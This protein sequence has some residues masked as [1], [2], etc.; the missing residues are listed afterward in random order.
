[1]ELAFRAMDLALKRS[2]AVVAM[3]GALKRSCAEP[4]VA[5]VSITLQNRSVTPAVEPAKSKA[6]RQLVMLG[7]GLAISEKASKES[8]QRAAALESSKPF[9]SSPAASVKELG[10]TGPPEP[11]LAKSAVAAAIGK[12]PV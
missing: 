10:F 4:A 6:P 1:M 12:G 11:R 7:E 8:V 2:R 3:G 5:E 9:P